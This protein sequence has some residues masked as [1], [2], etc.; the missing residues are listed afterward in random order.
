VHAEIAQCLWTQEYKNSQLPVPTVLV[1]AAEGA[2]Q[3]PAPKSR[4]GES[5]TLRSVD[6]PEKSEETILCPQSRAKRESPS[7]NC[8]P[9]VQGPRSNQEQDPSDSCPHLELKDSHQE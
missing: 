8:A 3:L 6:A 2:K 4:G 9:W 7:A 5:W 1:C